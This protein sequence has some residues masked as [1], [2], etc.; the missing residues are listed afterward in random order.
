MRAGRRLWTVIAVLRN[1]IT[2]RA[3]LVETRR[4]FWV[5]DMTL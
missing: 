1:L 3:D 4:R 5:Q 2:Q